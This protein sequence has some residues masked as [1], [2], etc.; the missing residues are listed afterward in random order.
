MLCV[1][2]KWIELIVPTIYA[3]FTKN[4]RKTT[5]TNVR[6]IVINSTSFRHDNGAWHWRMTLEHD[7]GA[8]QWRTTMEHDKCILHD[9]PHGCKNKVSDCLKLEANYSLHQSVN[10]AAHSGSETQKISHQKSKSRGTS[11]PKYNFIK[12]ITIG[13]YTK[14]QNQIP[15]G[16]RWGFRCCE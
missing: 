16:S 11:D 10:M 4:V 9:N 15:I 2:D 5:S 12:L 13:S 1:S 6:P 14:F 7:N 8:W 3:L